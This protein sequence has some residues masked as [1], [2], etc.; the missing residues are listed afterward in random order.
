MPTSTEK[1]NNTSP[2]AASA[3]TDINGTAAVR[4]CGKIR[5]RS[6]RA[7][8]PRSSVVK[9]PARPDVRFEGGRV[10]LEGESESG[11][12]FPELTRRAHVDRID[13]G[14]R[15]FYATPGVDFDRE[16]GPRHAVLLLH[17]RLLRCRGPRRP[18]HR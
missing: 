9:E 15:G 8:R 6:G 3:S 17:D 4:A 11:V 2:T 7:L 16:T 10:F 5:G 14:A 12:D 1:N 13:L 18:T